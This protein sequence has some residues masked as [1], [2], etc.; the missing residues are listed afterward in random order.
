LDKVADIICPM[1]YPSHYSWSRKFYADPYY[2]VHETSTR[3]KLRS[4][5]AMIVTYI[6]AFKMKMSG[7]PFDKYVLVDSS[8]EQG[9]EIGIV[10]LKRRLEIPHIAL[11]DRLR[12]CKGI[13]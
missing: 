9:G 6:Q 2:T 13:Q 12:C 4:K 5:N 1:A 7:I 11:S 10:Y 8:P 3:A